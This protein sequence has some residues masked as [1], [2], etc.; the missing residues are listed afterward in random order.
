MP[1]LSLLSFPEC[2]TGMSSKIGCATR[3]LPDSTDVTQWCEQ[4]VPGRPVT[5]HARSALEQLIID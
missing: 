3:E 5:T 2:H 4:Y 1:T